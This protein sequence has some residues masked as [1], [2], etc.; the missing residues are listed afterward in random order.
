MRAASAMPT[1]I[2][3]PWPS[4]PVEASTPGTLPASGWPPRIESRRQNVS[5]VSSGKKP[6]SASIDVERDAAVA[7]AEDHA[8]APAPVRLCGPVAQ[9]VVVEHAHD[10]DQRQRRA[11]MAALAAGKRAHDQPAQIVRALVERRGWQACS[12]RSLSALH[13]IAQSSTLRQCRKRTRARV[14][15]A[16]PWHRSSSSVSPASDPALPALGNE[17]VQQDE[18]PAQAEQREITPRAAVRNVRSSP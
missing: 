15:L 6:L 4:A 12:E 10:L 1:P 14:E 8:V 18:H 5:S 3:R 16:A 11:D 13:A 7:L 17:L 9:H 2:D